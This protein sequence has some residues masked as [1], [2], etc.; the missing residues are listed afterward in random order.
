VCFVV[1]KTISELEHA[2]L[3]IVY[4]AGAKNTDKDPFADDDVGA[5]S[6]RNKI[7]S[8]VGYQS[9]IFFFHGKAPGWVSDGSGTE[10]GTRES[11]SD[12]MVDSVSLLASIQ[13][14]RYTR[15]VIR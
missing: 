5:N 1:H 2:I 15:V 10:V 4:L 13:K 9:I 11:G 7:P 3:T 14:P 12:E 8:F 6:L